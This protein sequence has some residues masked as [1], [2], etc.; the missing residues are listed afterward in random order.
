MRSLDGMWKGQL[1]GVLEEAR[2]A[3]LAVG[4]DDVYGIGELALE[5]CDAVAPGLKVGVSD[6]SQR[7]ALGRTHETSTKEQP[8]C[9]FPDHDVVVSVPPARPVNHQPRVIKESGS[10]GRIDEARDFLARFGLQ[11]FCRVWSPR[12][13]YRAW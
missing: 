1:V 3:R 5:V 2:V 13:G 7:G 9:R 11:E 6:I 4:G 10:V 8:V 12:W